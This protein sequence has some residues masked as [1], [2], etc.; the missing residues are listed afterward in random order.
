MIMIDD[1]DDDDDDDRWLLW[2]LLCV[3]YDGYDCVVRRIRK[4]MMMMIMVMYAYVYYKFLS[5]YWLQHIMIYSCSST[6]RC[7]FI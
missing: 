7:I 2:W 6:I 4:T 3:C 5:P 1:D